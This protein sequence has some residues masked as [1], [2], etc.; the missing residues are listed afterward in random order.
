M[1]HPP[2]TD[3]ERAQAAEIERLKKDAQRYR[4]LREIN[5]YSIYDRLF[6]DCP[7]NKFVDELL[8]DAVD[9]AID[10]AMKGQTS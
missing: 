4:W 1:I 9:A 10:A 8:D 6:A 7:R 3:R 5:G 2:I